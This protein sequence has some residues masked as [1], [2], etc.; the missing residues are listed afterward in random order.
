MSVPAWQPSTRS[1]SAP[2]PRSSSRR[3]GTTPSPSPI[4]AKYGLNASIWTS[5]PETGRRLAARIEAGGVFINAIPASDPRLP[6]GGIKR[7]GYGR[8]LG[9]HGI[10]AF[11]NAQTVCDAG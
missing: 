1:C 9:A 5:D 7:S 4:A 11:M 6:I 2:S 10:R 3:T 8:E